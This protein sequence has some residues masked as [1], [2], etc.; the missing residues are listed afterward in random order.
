MYPS[1]LRTSSTFERKIE[2]GA[3][4]LDLP[5]RWPLRMRVS[6]SPKGS[7][8]AIARLL[9]PYQLDLTMPG[10]WPIDARSRRAMREILNFR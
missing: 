7:L 4:T 3:L 9:P 1:R 6:M 8:I 2:A 5:T 10:I